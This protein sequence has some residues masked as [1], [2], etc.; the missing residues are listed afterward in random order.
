MINSV[1]D[2][3]SNPDFSYDLTITTISISIS[4]LLAFCVWLMKDAYER[5]VLETKLLL[6]IEMYLI[7]DRAALLQN[8][9]SFDEWI[10]SLKINRA[11][12]F[13]F[14]NYRT[15]N[16]DFH[17]I[18]NLELL[19]KLNRLSYSLTGFES[20]E[21]NTLEE[22]RQGL[23][24]FFNSNSVDPKHWE[25]FNENLRS[26]LEVRKQSYDD[27]IKDTEEALALLRAHKKQKLF[28]VFRL[29]KKLSIPIPGLSYKVVED[30]LKELRKSNPE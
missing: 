12:S 16:V 11:R 7:R 4:A 21:K 20:D 23:Q 28:S 14:R 27:A 22:Y 1:V 5:W 13:V 15:D 24:L 2:N 25:Q 9:E 26:Q 29:V 30:E 17:E 3:F 18:S 6:K 19:N 8:K 10:G